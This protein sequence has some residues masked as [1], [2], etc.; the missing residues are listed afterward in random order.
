MPKLDHDNFQQDFDDW[1]EIRVQLTELFKDKRKPTTELMENG[2]VLLA[3]VLEKAEGAAPLN[4]EERFAFIKKNKH[5]YAAFRQLDELFNET[6][7]KIAR[8]RVMKTPK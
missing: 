8:L 4:F 7:K 6:K 3:N 1:I 2:I 5:N